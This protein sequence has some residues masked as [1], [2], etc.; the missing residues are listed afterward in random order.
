MGNLNGATTHSYS[1]H[2]GPINGSYS[3]TNPCDGNCGNTGTYSY[4]SGVNLGVASGTYGYN[5][6]RDDSCGPKR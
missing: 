2:L 3:Y 6:T 5:H 1:G 4:T